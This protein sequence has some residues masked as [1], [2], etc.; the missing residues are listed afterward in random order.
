MV[1]LNNARKLLVHG[2]DKKVAE[3]NSFEFRDHCNFI[4]GHPVK[5]AYIIRKTGDWCIITDSAK[6]PRKLLKIKMF[7]DRRVEIT[8]RYNLNTSR[9]LQSRREARAV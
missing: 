3:I 5:N 8:A 6:D 4:L 9:A 7:L 2:I 1:N